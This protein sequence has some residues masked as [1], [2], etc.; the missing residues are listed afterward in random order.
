MRC[1]AQPFQVRL[2]L[3]DEAA[4]RV[5]Q[6]NGKASK[7]RFDAQSKK[8]VLVSGRQDFV[9]RLSSKKRGWMYDR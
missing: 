1:T 9:R 8:A 7:A 2:R 3:F 6:P 4:R 5:S